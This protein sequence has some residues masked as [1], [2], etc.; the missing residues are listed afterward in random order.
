MVEIRLID[1]ESDTE[2]V[3]DVTDEVDASKSV[4]AV[5]I[6][7]DDGSNSGYSFYYGSSDNSSYTPYSTATIMANHRSGMMRAEV[8]ATIDENRRK[9]KAA[10][11]AHRHRRQQIVYL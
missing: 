7:Y 3:I 6:V 9:L 1:S 10:L 4:P 2:S 11:K 8:K 5:V